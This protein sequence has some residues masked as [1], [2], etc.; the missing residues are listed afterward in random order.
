[1]HIASCVSCSSLGPVHLHPPSSLAAHT[2]GARGHAASCVL[3]DPLAMLLEQWR[4]LAGKMAMLC[5]VLSARIAVLG[6]LRRH[7]GHFGPRAA[8]TRDAHEVPSPS[9]ASEHKRCPLLHCS[10]RPAGASVTRVRIPPHRVLLYEVT[11][12]RGEREGMP[13]APCILQAPQLLNPPKG[14]YILWVHAISSRSLWDMR[15]PPLTKTDHALQVLGNPVVIVVSFASAA[16]AVAARFRLHR[17]AHPSQA[18]SCFARAALVRV[19][20]K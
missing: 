15:G 14:P 4:H 16:S 9:S 20:S 3:S 8:R 7:T 5:S 1:M 17:A 10:M 12:W 6:R 2:A 11:P 13:T 19:T 18:C